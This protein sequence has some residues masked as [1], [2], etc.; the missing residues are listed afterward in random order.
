MHHQIGKLLQVGN[1]TNSTFHQ[2]FNEE[3]RKAEGKA[4]EAVKS[5]LT[6]A[7][8]PQQPNKPTNEFLNRKLKYDITD[9]GEVRVLIQ[10]ADGEIVKYIPPEDIRETLSTSKGN[11]FDLKV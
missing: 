9:D 3:F 10:S 5:D 1:E 11:F 2:T 7:N 8:A 4:D 6:V